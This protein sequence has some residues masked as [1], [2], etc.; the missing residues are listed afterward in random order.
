MY[1]NQKIFAIV[2]AYNEEEHIEMV[3]KTIPDYV[4]KIIVVD[5]ASKDNT[6]EIANKCDDSRLLIL[7]N[8]VNQGVGGAILTG[9]KKAIELG[10]DVCAIMAGDGQMDPTYLPKLLDALIEEKFDYSK[11]NRF[12]EQGSLRGMPKL[13]I[14]G[15]IFLTFLSKIATGYWNIFD[16]QNGYTAINCNVLKELDLNNI[17]KDYNFENDMLFHLNIKKCRVKDVFIPSRYLYEK[18]H[19]KINKFIF[20]SIFFFLKKFIMRIWQRYI[21][22]DFHPIALL[23]LSGLI[24]TLSGIFFGSYIIYLKLTYS[25]TPSTGTVML[26]VIPF[27][28]GFQLLLASFILDILET[29]K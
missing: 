25:M 18:S 9:H 6:F 17:E 14:F 12:L 5:D 27:M 24:L 11:G 8:S 15:N 23:L 26:S 1:K 4:D 22:R 13:R 20:R 28:L 19:I 16:P 29:P 21:L 7:R 3:I 2:P 10:G